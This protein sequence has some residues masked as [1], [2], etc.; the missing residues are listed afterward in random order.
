MIHHMNCSLVSTLI[1]QY[2][3]SSVPR[4]EEVVRNTRSEDRCEKKIEKVIKNHQI[5]ENIILTK[6]FLH[7]FITEDIYSFFQHL[8]ICPL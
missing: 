8:Q 7:F 6:C 1:R 5:L 4:S 2:I 3:Q